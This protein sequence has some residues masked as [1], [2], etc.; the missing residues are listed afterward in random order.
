ML[1]HTVTRPSW[2]N[3]LGTIGAA[4]L[5]FAAAAGLRTFLLIRQF[6]PSLTRHRGRAE[7][8]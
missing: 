8:G 2:S 5:L 4:G 3:A 1:R 6:A 7:F